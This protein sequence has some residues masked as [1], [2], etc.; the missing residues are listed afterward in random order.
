MIYSEVSYLLRNQRGVRSIKFI[1]SRVNF[2]NLFVTT[3]NETKQNKKIKINV[4]NEQLSLNFD[5]F[6]YIS[7][8]Y[9]HPQ[10]IMGIESFSD[11]DSYD[12][13]K[14]REEFNKIYWS[15]LSLNI[16]AIDLS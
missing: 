16:N 5:N 2:I 13:Y 3:Q 12:S 4:G 7:D 10:Q 15:E 1:F 9:S 6:T 11:L 8:D 14:L